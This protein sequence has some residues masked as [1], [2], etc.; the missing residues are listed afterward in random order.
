MP[1]PPP[2]SGSALN[3]PDDVQLTLTR[4]IKMDEVLRHRGFAYGPG[5]CCVCS[6]NV[7]SN[8]KK[9]KYT[10]RL[11]ARS[12]RTVEMSFEEGFFSSP[13]VAF[14]WLLYYFLLQSTSKAV[15]LVDVFV[16][17][18]PVIWVLSQFNVP[19]GGDRD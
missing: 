12:D 7:Q 14:L 1:F 19:K 11:M 3:S 8:N 17:S 2:L 10:I 6:E 16:D 18:E 4:V 13:P 5:K 15:Y 9:S